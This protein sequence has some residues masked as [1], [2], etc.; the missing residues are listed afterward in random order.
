ML[1]KEI[2]HLW[3]N[4][5]ILKDTKVLLLFSLRDPKINTFNSI[6]DMFYHSCEIKED[7]R[8]YAKYFE[9]NNG[10]GL[11][12]L[13][14]GFDEHPKAMQSGTLFYK[15][16]VD[17]KI[18][19]EAC[20][21]ITSRPHE[22]TQLQKYISYRIEIVGFTKNRRCDFVQNN[23]KEKAGGLLSYLEDHEII[24]TLCYIPL[25]MSIVVY[26][27]KS[28]VKLDDLPNNQTEL[29]KQAVRMTVRHNLE[30]LKPNLKM[31]K[32]KNDLE[33]LPKPF[34]E[35]FYYL[36]E[37]AYKALDEKKLTFTSDEI[38]KA[39]P[40]QTN[41]DEKIERAII[42]GLG[43][44]HAAQFF[45]KGDVE[46]LSNFA[47]YSVQELLAAWYI[48]YSNRSYFQQ[49]S[50]PCS[51]Q[52]SMQ[53]CSQIIFQIQKLKATFWE[54]DYINVWSFY[55][56]L[57][58][59][60][61]LAFKLFLTSNMFSCHMLYT[62][63][64]RLQGIFSC[65][66][67][68]EATPNDI[69]EFM[70]VVQCTKKT[71]K[72]KLK[73]LLLY[74]VLQE[75]PDSEIIKQFDAVI[76]KDM[77]DISEQVLDSKGDLYLLGNILSRPYLTK[78]WKT[79]NLSYCQIDDKKFKILV[80]VLTRNDGRFKPKIEVLSL[81][82]NKL[83][84]CSD[85][86]ANLT[87][88]QEILHLDLS[89][90]VLGNFISLQRCDF[91]VTLDISNN[92]LYNGNVAISL[93]ALR[94]LR[95]LK[96]LQLKHNNIGNNQDAI[97]AIGLALCSCNCLEEL[98]LDGND[99]G[100]VE[101]T[102][103]LFRV[104]KELRN[105][106]SDEHHYNGQP[107]K[108]SAFLKILE[109]CNKIDYEPHMCT[110]R[111]II[112]QS[113]VIDIS[114]NGLETDD[115]CS[116]GQNLPLLTNLKKLII[117]ENNI[118]DEATKSLT[119]G[120]LMLLTPNL[121]Q[122]KYDKNMFSDDSTI[123]FKMIHRLQKTSA[124]LPFECPPPKIE[125]LLFILNCINDNKEKVQSSNI[126][127][128]IGLITELNLSH[129][130]PTTL[131]HKLTIEDIKK[132]C[133]VLRWFKQLEV[134]D[135][136]NNKIT[137]EARTSLEM[138][139]LQIYTLNSIKLI[140]NP[141]CDDKPSMAV[142]ETITNVREKRLDS[143]VCNQNLPQHTG[144]H[145]LLQIMDCLSQFENPSCSKSFDN[146]ITV[147]VD[148][149]AQYGVK[150]LECLTFLPFLK[151]LKI[152][153]VPCITDSGMHQLG[154]YL[155]QNRTLTTLDLSY[156]NLKNLEIELEIETS[157]SIPI[158]VLKLNHSNVTDK[159]LS[160][161][162][163]MM[164]L[165]K[166]IQLEL[167]GNYFG[168]KGIS[169][170]CIKL[171]F[172]NNQPMSITTLNLADNQLT[173]NSAVEIFNM[174]TMHK[175][176][177]LNISCNDLRGILPHFENCTTTTLVELNI[178]ANN[179][180]TDNSMEFMKSLN[181]LDS[182]SSLKKLNISDN[183]IDNTANNE[184]FRFLMTHGHLEE[185]MC[186]GNP[187]ENEIDLAFHLVKN[188]HSQQGCVKQINFKQQSALAQ[189][190]ISNTALSYK[191]QIGTCAKLQVSQV[192]SIDFSY[193]YMEI[194]EDFICL[195]ENCF[196]LETL[197][198]EH[199]KITTKAFKYYVATGI[200]FTSKL[201]PSKLQLSG[202]PCMVDKPKNETVLEIIQ[203]LRS[204]SI[205]YRPPNFEQFLTVLELVDSINEKQNDV[206][207]HISLITHLDIRYSGQ[208]S[209]LKNA[210]QK[211]QSY[212]IKNFC[213]YLK[214]LKELKSI[215]MTG[216]NIEEDAKDDLAIA[217]LKHPNINEIQLKG[218]PIH[219]I[220]KCNRLFDT[221]KEMHMCGRSFSLK[222]RLEFESLEALVT[223]LQFIQDF[224]DK[225][226]CITNSIE[227][228][229]VSWF[230]QP[231]YKSQFGTEKI[232]EMCIK[233]I[234][235]L[236]LFCKLK[237]LNLS[238]VYLTANGLQELS[239][240]LQ[241]NDTLLELD[242]SHN[243]TQ[244]E[245]ALV[246][247]KSLNKNKPLIK[248]LNL[249]CNKITGEKCDEI[250]EIIHSLNIHADISGN[251]LTEKSKYILGIK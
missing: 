240:F 172:K 209:N 50:L 55:V 232:D 185:V 51:I 241:N 84:S 74:Y 7:A 207:K 29:T 166:L 169:I 242:I 225:T 20:I 200:M 145:P 212:D 239:R 127:S 150:I 215:D 6:E 14:D 45:N 5:Q 121:K 189:A 109:H 230:Y 72:N 155:S 249:A 227:Q 167:E 199:N 177:C 101:K 135:V 2:R 106:N 22:T 41:G 21:I 17:E 15:I 75:A 188:Q 191:D 46:L 1:M 180:N 250:A 213:K 244:A 115:G 202:N 60:N 119:T 178:S 140:G 52:K 79:V 118:T 133:A 235:H 171:S 192:T 44:I 123:I 203:A 81:S 49:L 184:V 243:N 222:R 24:D 65:M 237:T 57:T 160:K 141:I 157:N 224:N 112:M 8:I 103:L 42:N 11:V 226:Y 93:T 126:V 110:L 137:V 194:N 16:L 142:F 82:G 70:D 34:N 247:L 28:N 198:M 116:L 89:K 251:K 97:D 27:C 39:C 107:N 48:A 181:F 128:T 217:L 186:K 100:F 26:L 170:L 87:C 25:N 56:G 67:L 69:P 182:C 125:A 120:M 80:E 78:Q 218:N 105:S 98:E 92:K 176:K 196:Q 228:L 13:L 108:A 54:G 163:N 220:S 68:Q 149:E 90:N 195:L 53:N 64:S 91:L 30:K 136:S 4:D 102:A 134:L 71:L 152:N 129:S 158:E 144:F 35:I 214:Y 193:N 174:V 19:L 206:I 62:S 40:V 88:R 83:K 113:N 111:N 175:V 59:G 156:C 124:G 73:A 168:D 154:R 18:F 132:L 32:S 47:H 208:P 77:L 131:D 197:N 187:A 211:L 23:L 36:T 238:H 229:N 117:T 162:L 216:N 183:N 104:I 159:L 31:T 190:L 204:K 201:L 61:D 146:I 63:F 179:H 233:L 3:A 76:T 138:L 94:T 58:G 151:V 205:Y 143:I 164:T 234:H 246:V 86:I 245:G 38:S 173:T 248:K 33:N 96:V 148:S 10:K 130:E 221:I 95:K 210:N 153:N 161:F 231:Q 9:R 165:T 37:L 66:L 139:M 85:D 12:I 223:I 147:D 122:F 99:R 114:G 236:K 43:L 219:K